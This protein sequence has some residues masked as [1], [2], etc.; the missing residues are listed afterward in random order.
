MSLPVGGDFRD[1]LWMDGDDLRRDAV[2]VV[3]IVAACLRLLR[4]E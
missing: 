1:G 3:V 2:L 4:D